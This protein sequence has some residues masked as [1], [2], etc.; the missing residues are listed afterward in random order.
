MCGRS[1][2]TVEYFFGKLFE[3]PSKI[4]RDLLHLINELSK[5]SPHETG[6]GCRPMRYRGFTLISANSS[7]QT[8]LNFTPIRMN[9][10]AKTSRQ[11]CFIFS[12][13]GSQFATINKQLLNFDVI[14][15]SIHKSA[16]V[17]RDKGVDLLTLLTKPN[18]DSNNWVLNTILS[19]VAIQMALTDQLRH[20]DITADHMIGYSIGEIVCAYADGCLTVRETLLVAYYCGNFIDKMAVKKGLKRTSRH[21]NGDNMGHS[22]DQYCN[23]VLTTGTDANLDIET[24]VQTLDSVIGSDRKMSSKCISNTNDYNCHNINSK[25]FVDCL[26]LPPMLTN[27]FA[28]CV[29][30]GSVIVDLSPDTLMANEIMNLN[31][32]YTY[33]PLMKKMDDNCESL[34]LTGLGRLY[35]HGF[36]V[37][38]ERLYPTVGGPVST[39]TR[40]LSPFIQWNHTKSYLGGPVSTGTRML[41][42]FIQWNHTKSYREIRFPDYFN[43]FRNL[44]DAS[45]TID[46]RDVNDQYILDHCIDGKILF[47]GTGYLMLAWR[48]LAFHK[49]ISYKELSVE[50]RDVQ[51]LRATPVTADKKVTFNVNLDR[52]TGRFH[53]IESGSIAVSGT[54]REITGDQPLRYTSVLNE[55]QS[56]ADTSHETPILLQSNDVYKMLRTRG[57]NYGP[58][59]R[60]ITDAHEIRDTYWSAGIEWRQNW[61]T[62]CDC[63][64]QTSLITRSKQLV[65]PVAIDELRCDP[66]QLFSGQVVERRTVFDPHLNIMV[67]PGL[68]I[69]G[70]RTSPLHRDVKSQTPAHMSYKFVAFDENFKHGLDNDMTCSSYDERTCL[71]SQLTIF[72]QNLNQLSCNRVNVLEVNESSAPMYGTV[73]S[74]IDMLHYS[75]DV[76]FVLIGNTIGFNKED[77]NL[78]SNTFTLNDSCLG[79][80]VNDGNIDLIVYK[81]QSLCNLTANE[82]QTGKNNTLFLHFW[83]N[84]IENGFLLIVLKVGMDE[85]VMALAQKIGFRMV[86]HKKHCF[87]VHSLLFRKIIIDPLIE[88]Q[89][90]IKFT[91]DYRLWLQR[92]Q[93][94]FSEIGNKSIEQNIWLVANGS[95]EGLLGFMN[96]IRKEPN[97]HRIRCL[98]IMD[99]NNDTQRPV[100]SDK[101]NTMLNDIIKNDLAIN[102]LRDGKVGHY[103]LNELP[104]RRKTIDT[105]HCF[106]NLQN[107]G[108]LSSFQWFE[109]Q[110]KYWPLNRKIGEKLVHIYYSAL[111]F[112]DIMLATGQSIGSLS[113]HLI[114]NS[115]LQLK[116]PDGETECLIG[117]EFAGRDEN[118]NRVMGMVLSKALATT[119]LVKEIHFLWPI[120]DH[121]SMEE[122]ATVPC[123]YGTAYYALIIRGKLRPKESVLIH[124]GSGGVGQA[125]IRICLSLNCRLLITVGSDAKRQFLQELFPSLGDECFSTSRDATAFRRHVMTET[126]GAGVDVVLNSLSDEKLFASLECLATN[127]RFLEIGIYDFVKDSL[128]NLE[129]SISRSDL[130]DGNVDTFSVVEHD[131]DLPIVGVNRIRLYPYSKHLRTVC[132]RFELYGCP[133]DVIDC[134]T[135]TILLRIPE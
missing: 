36:N 2:A 126:D 43:Y 72:A 48:S 46:F 6:T 47:P 41:S 105:E 38:I 114:P 24:L 87:A 88:R 89:I 111:N 112:K 90:I 30:N 82:I 85:E 122:A 54:V 23:E 129:E 132:L 80:D 56:M 96:C 121:W 110:H 125:A 10:V 116:A 52:S 131:L 135:A 81:D 119:C 33:I 55:I 26:L 19:A 113:P 92:F 67:T 34:L 57:Y 35:T 86:S 70:V 117:S 75:L 91:N 63:L 77:K 4:S 98:Q 53:I 39:G 101:T 79:S 25:Y 28:N 109:C 74:A 59:F 102:V 12:G 50:F 127:G 73:M 118:M 64:L 94:E 62:F 8:G 124:S 45:Y 32:N 9:K 65:V 16:V 103:V 123:V 49:K 120:P 18:A 3:R 11:L 20:L 21:L 44:S 68:E 40:M 69:R 134:M 133:Y 51:L 60:C 128:L 5:S 130:L 106:L 15:N 71:R 66:K 42:P 115:R 31:T 76:N 37:S 83:Q 29:P 99:T 93:R 97:G 108:D 104:V 95:A 17:L 14:S 1:Q 22:L 13:N 84:L 78:Y 58:S 7:V 61:V 27:T 107:R 100:V